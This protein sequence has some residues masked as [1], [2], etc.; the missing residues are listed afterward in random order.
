MGG[1]LLLLVAIFVFAGGVG[2][3]GAVAGSYLFAIGL[4]DL[5]RKSTDRAQVASIDSSTSPASGRLVKFKRPLL[6]IVV[7]MVFGAIG[8][9]T[10]FGSGSDDLKAVCQGVENESDVAYGSGEPPFQ[11]YSVTG[12]RGPTTTSPNRGYGA[13]GSGVTGTRL[14]ISCCAST[15]SRCSPMVC[16]RLNLKARGGKWSHSASGT[17]R[18]SAKRKPQLCWTRLSSS[19][20]LMA[21]RCFPF[22]GMAA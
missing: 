20:N 6:I 10:Y 12:E 1:V 3:L 18:R 11:V 9:A 21:V 13:A 7:A 4:R 5:R 19:P 15:E 22:T 14:S 16:A 2:L 8:L 17:L